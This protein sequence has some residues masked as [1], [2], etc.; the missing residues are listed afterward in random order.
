MNNFFHKLFNPHCPDCKEELRE[1]KI[2]EVVEGL[3]L[4]NARMQEMIDKLFD[5]LLEKPE[6]PIE[7]V[8]PASTV[9]PAQI[10]WRVRQQM[11]EADDRKTAQLLK[12]APKPD[13]EV[14]KLEVELGVSDAI[15]GSN[16]KIQERS[17]S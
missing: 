12:E 16:E 9:K 17:A 4:E 2:N 3:K 14:T 5:R 11:L 8:K 10:P 6:T 1:S 7:E 13:P 15:P